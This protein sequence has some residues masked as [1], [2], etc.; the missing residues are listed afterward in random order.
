MVQRDGLEAALSRLHDA[1][2]YVTLEEFK[3]RAPICRPGL[4]FEVSERDFDNPLLT[5]HYEGLTGGSRG[6][7]SRVAIDFEFWPTRV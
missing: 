7:G 6:G 1:G 3:G 5:A 4:E 2:V